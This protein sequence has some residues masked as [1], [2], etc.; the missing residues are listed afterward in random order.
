M[1]KRTRP[2]EYYLRKN[3]NKKMRKTTRSARTRAGYSSTARTRGAAVT[4]EMKYFDSTLAATAIPQSATMTGAVLDPATFNCLCCPVVGSAVNQRIG[5]S[6]KIL[7]LKINGAMLLPPTEAVATAISANNIRLVV[8]MDKETNATQATGAQL[9][10]IVGA[11]E[12]APFTFQNIDSFGRFQVLKD[13]TYSLQNPNLA[14]DAATH[15]QNGLSTPFKFNFSFKKPIVVRFNATN[16]GSV[17]DIVDFSLHVFAVR[18]GSTPVY[19]NYNSRCC[20]KE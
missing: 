13:K 9:M 12:N 10:S 2:D 11:V 8:F 4:G 16:G 6:I 17:A 14:G 5:R 15:D 3:E 1:V 19:L 18:N 20:Y 7:K